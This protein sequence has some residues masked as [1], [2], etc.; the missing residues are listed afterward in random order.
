[1]KAKKKHPWAQG[2]SLC[3]EGFDLRYFQT[4]LPITPVKFYMVYSKVLIE[5]FLQVRNKSQTPG[6]CLL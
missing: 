5:Y 2:K 1:M 3:F 6:L 4:L